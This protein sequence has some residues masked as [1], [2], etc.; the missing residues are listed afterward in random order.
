MGPLPNIIINCPANFYPENVV[1]FLPPLQNFKIPSEYILTCSANT[2]TP[3]DLLKYM[4]R[5]DDNVLHIMQGDKN[6]VA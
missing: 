1:C 6:P 4:S 3:N 2:T 5:R